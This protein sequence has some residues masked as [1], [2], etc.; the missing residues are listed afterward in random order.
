M[1]TND[2]TAEGGGETVEACAV[3][4]T[5]RQGDEGREDTRTGGE[6]RTRRE[7]D[8]TTERRLQTKVCHSIFLGLVV[9]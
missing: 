8:E 4:G 1:R 9:G 5:G 6:A 2:G 7:S 3:G